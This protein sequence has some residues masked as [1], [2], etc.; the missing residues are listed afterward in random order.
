MDLSKAFDAINHDLFLS[1][2]KACVLLKILLQLLEAILETGRGERKLV[3]TSVTGAK[4]LLG[5]VWVR[6]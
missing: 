6:Y 5:F 1:K 4:L 3:A 2:L